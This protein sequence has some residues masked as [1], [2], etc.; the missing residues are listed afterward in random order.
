MSTSIFGCGG[1]TLNAL[2]AAQ[3]KADLIN[4]VDP[5][6]GAD[7]VSYNAGL[8]YDAGT[9]GYAIQH[10]SGGGAANGVSMVASGAD[11]TGAVDCA[12]ILA[13]VFAALPDGGMIVFDAG[14][15]FTLSTAVLNG[16]RV[17]ILADGA[18]INCTS[19]A[20]AIHKTDHVGQLRIL[21]GNWI[22]TGVATCINYTATPTAALVYD[23]LV[24]GASFTSAAAFAVWMSGANNV[25]F[26]DCAFISTATSGVNYTRGGVYCTLTNNPYLFHCNFKGNGYGCGFFADGQ[27]NPNSSNPVLRDCELLT[28]WTNLKISGCDDFLLDKV[29]SDY[30]TGYN[31]IISSQ[32]GGSVIN[33]YFGSS[34]SIAAL[35]LCSEGVNGWGPDNCQKITVSN[36]AFTGHLVTNGAYDNVLLSDTV[37]GA[38]ASSALYPAEIKFI[39]CHFQFWT[40]Y[41]INFG[42][43]SERLLI[44]GCDFDPRAGTGTK[45]IYNSNA[46]G[47]DSATL[48]VN[49]QFPNGTK[50]YIDAGFQFAQF[51]NNTGLVE[52]IV[53]LDHASLQATPNGNIGVGGPGSSY[54]HWVNQTGPIQ[55]DRWANAPTFRM[56]RANSAFTLIPNVANGVGIADVV[57][58]LAFDAFNATTLVYQNVAQI[59]AATDGA[60]DGTH[61]PGRLKFSITPNSLGLNA[62]T[63]ALDIDNNGNVIIDASNNLAALDPGILWHSNT[64]ATAIGIYAGVSY[65][66]SFVA[67][68]GSLAL[69]TSGGF[70][71]RSNNKWTTA[72]NTYVYANTSSTV[73]ANGSNATR[74]AFTN[75]ASDIGSNWSG[76]TFT[77]PCAGLYQVS[78]AI[79]FTAAGLSIVNEQTRLEIYKNGLRYLVGNSLVVQS[80]TAAING[81]IVVFGT[82]QCAAGDTIELYVFCNTSGGNPSANGTA[83]GNY[84]T[85]N[86]VL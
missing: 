23:M 46:A 82:V 64:K 55:V 67:G 13:T 37:G 7:L 77:A 53:N 59:T 66:P 2:T 24:S 58:T 47:G 65:P 17:T 27:G 31:N 80:T 62:L 76:T 54:W 28:W 69:S 35:I 21:G 42:M 33:C 86:R 5:A 38:F 83:A 25:T 20:G 45:A 43:A 10:T 19:G 85:I 30:S 73:F 68:T 72:L 18:T 78:G 44:F 14:C 8:A 70:A 16:K 9:V 84:I 29:T 57:G 60:Q 75:T 52:D 12:G 32:D 11:G 3:L 63:N 74:V 41:A 1:N 49:N 34:T 6:Q 71:L 50:L 15:S 79:I 61:S 56:R 26:T 36:T 48:I 22:A 40:K 39:G 51:F 4:A 81:N